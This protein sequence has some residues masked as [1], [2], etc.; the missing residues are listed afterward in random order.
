MLTKDFGR[1]FS[2]DSV[3]RKFVREDEKDTLVKA[4][5]ENTVSRE[6]NADGVQTSETILNVVSGRDLTEDELLKA[7][8]LDPNE[9][10][11]ARG[12]SNYY[13]QSEQTTSF[14]TKIQYQPR[15]NIR[16]SDIVNAFDEDLKQYH[17][18]KKK[19]G[20][21]NLVVPFA[22]LHFGWTKF[23]DIESKVQEIIEI[24]ESR[25]Y[26][27]IVF[28]DLGDMFHSDQIASSQTVSG[29]LLDDVD[30]R[31]GIK[32]AIKMF[33]AILPVAFENSN[34]VQL[35]SVYGNHDMDISYMFLYALENRFPQLEIDKNDDTE[36]T[37]WRTSF[38][39]GN[40]AIMMAHGS[41]APKR[42]D[43]LF[44]IE[45]KKNWGLG[46]THEI[47]SG[48]Y[49]TEKFQNKNGIMFRQLGTP[50]PNDP[51]EIKNGFTGSKQVMYVFEYD[52]NRMKCMYEV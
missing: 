12:T 26:D 32:D 19:N 44:P 15:K 46:E 30:M 11:I 48:H 2:E 40:V 31:Q 9:F 8:N 13:K 39:L 3:R 35:K 20:K 24:I 47:F 10:E 27:N 41:Y 4:S 45:Y 7:H 52:E 36:N 42:L 5:A 50:K 29:T 17:F 18:A 49:H 28:M 38:M 43:G 14:Q 33:D 1:T 51:Y 21:R 22:D 23:E 34:N 6:Y 16:K 25:G 37:G